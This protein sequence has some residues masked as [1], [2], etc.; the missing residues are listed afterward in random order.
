MEDSDLLQNH[1][2]KLRVCCRIC[3]N[4]V[5]ERPYNKNIFKEELQ[6]LYKID[7][8]TDRTDIHPVF[9]CRE[10]A[11]EL[12]RVRESKNISFKR[13]RSVA[14]DFYPHSS[15]CDICK[16]R[17][18]GRPRKKTVS[19]DLPTDS[20]RHSQFQNLENP[21]LTASTSTA[22]D[23][24]KG[25]SFAVL[26]QVRDLLK[27][28]NVDDKKIFFQEFVQDLSTDDTSLLSYFL[29]RS[30]SKSAKDDC[31]SY[32]LLYKDLQA[33]ANID[34]HRWLINRNPNIILYLMGLGNFSADILEIKDDRTKLLTIARAVE[35]LYMIPC[36]STISPIS[37][38]LNV[39]NYAITGSKTTVDMYGSSSPGGHYKA[40]TQW[41]KEQGTV[42][43]V[44]PE[45]DLLNVFDNE[46][47][48]G[49]SYTIKPS[50]KQKISVITNKGVVSLQSSESVSMIQNNPNLKPNLVLAE[51]NTYTLTNESKKDLNEAVKEMIEQSSERCK[52][53]EKLHF[54][55]LHVSVHEAISIVLNEQ[56]LVD[57]Q[58]HDQIDE[59]MAADSIDQ[60]S[61]KCVD[62][63]TENSKR[64]LVCSG[65]NN[66]GGIK[67]AK[68]QMKMGLE[69]PTKP[70][71]TFARITFE[72]KDGCTEIK[73]SSVRYGHIT[74]N[75]KGKHEII[76]TD[77]VFC[78]PNSFET[79]ASVLR[80]IGMENGIKLYGGNKRHWTFVCCDGLPYMICKKL[81]EEAVICLQCN[82]KF[83][84]R[85][86]FVNH[87]KTDHPDLEE[88]PFLFEF[89]WFFLRIGAGHYEM[90]LIKSFIE[91][92]WVPFFETLAER[93]GF[94]SNAAKL[95]AKSCKDH[96]KS[97]TL[98]QIFH[99]GSLRELVLPYVRQCLL[100]G[101]KPFA[102]G[103]FK[104]SNEHYT[105]HNPNMKYLMDQV[106]RFSQG[107][108]NFRMAV[109]RNNSSLLKSA[110]FMTKELFHGRSHPKYQS[111]EIYDT[112]QDILMP[113]EVQTL[114]DLYSSITTS[115]NTSTGQDFDFVLEEKNKQ[116]KSWIPKGMP[117]DEIWQTVCRNNSILEKIKKNTLSLFGIG[118]E[119]NAFRHIDIEKAVQIL[120]SVFRRTGYLMK[121]GDHT[122]L[123]GLA[124]DE[125]LIDFYAE[126]TKKRIY[127]VQREI[128]KEE[129]DDSYFLRQPVPVTPDERRDY[130]SIERMTIDE[131]SR[132]IQQILGTIPDTFQFQY[133]NQL[134]YTEK[135]GWK[136]E[137]YVSFL[138]E[139]ADAISK[140]SSDI[141]Q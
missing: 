115:G 84:R 104:F 61:I 27:S 62:C 77:P 69:Q 26:H 37:F 58:V 17:N 21:D 108:I 97:W 54:E 49:K 29:G 136:K 117:T 41:L 45:G 14:T 32:S 99:Q 3:G 125:K 28:L 52:Q 90:N 35:H 127:N 53:M 4:K 75:H 74:S 65:C 134:F 103:F 38:L 86:D 23:P 43:A 87:G 56:R 2:E 139:L 130:L 13:R 80:K 11:R 16:P 5:G 106:C 59:K 83:L 109:R 7:I 55:Q 20:L 70:E 116:L 137:N 39:C 129:R 123:H 126:S 73:E 51:D 78:N 68:E 105:T 46:Q 110:K 118:L 9:I 8:E 132:Q 72:D 48:I 1:I 122:S 60:T 76:L 121:T 111:I 138:Q 102:K 89:D 44:C 133:H 63:G 114:N 30:V 100:N 79:V 93:M 131:L 6:C 15:S 66:R 10:D 124:L 91:L 18:S 96:H 107:I 22:S 19:K 33:V 128:L 71:P 31:E 25:F 57:G 119:S 141:D 98:L 64:K 88:C 95:Y 36:P 50:N 24:P 140:Q 135:K 34:I 94:V 120:Q 81:K 85:T 67:K 82:Q 113:K 92:N 101:E 42:P 112:L 47:I 12:Y 40:V